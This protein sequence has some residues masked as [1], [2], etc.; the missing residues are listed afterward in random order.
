MV[1]YFKFQ[2]KQ[3]YATLKH[4]QGAKLPIE[5]FAFVFAYQAKR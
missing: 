4:S 1:I 5:Y 3:Y 2:I